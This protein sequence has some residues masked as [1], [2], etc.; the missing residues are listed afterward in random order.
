M[1]YDGSDP[2]DSDV[3]LMMAMRNEE[4]LRLLLHRHGGCMK[5]YLVKHYGGLLQDGELAEA[6]SV[7]V[8]N[9]WRFAERYDEGNGTLPV[10]VHPHRTAVGTEHPPARVQVSLEESGVRRHF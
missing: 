5:A 4:G 7:A 6:L 10:V 8:Y 9:A 1:A 2:A 3:A